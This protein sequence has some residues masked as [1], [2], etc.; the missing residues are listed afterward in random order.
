MTARVHVTEFTDPAC[1]WAWGSEPALRWLARV[2]AGRVAWRRVFGILFDE[3]EDP[4]PDPEAETRWY[5]RF[6][7]G[8]AAHTH[9]PYAARLSRVSE[10]SWP[11][12]LAARAAQ[13]QG[14][15][16]AERVLRRL[17]EAALVRGVP[18]DRPAEVRTAVAGVP[19][20]DE[21]RL[22]ADLAAP[23]VRRAVRADWAETRRPEPEVL[24]LPERG[25]H[26]GRAKELAEGYRYAL[27][28]LVFSGPGGRYVAPGWRSPAEYLACAERAAGEPLP[29]PAPLPAAQAL[30]HYRTLTGP[31]L[32]LLTAE[33]EPPPGA[34]EFATP[35][36]SLWLHP[37]EAAVHPATAG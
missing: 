15:A 21:E 7:A 20:L 28:T 27:P 23:R 34:V 2:L 16:V 24:H 13:E 31:E 33:G 18:A 35:T 26:G 36:G 11:A 8:V 10:S 1:P 17:R 3:D 30:A 14:P 22:L 19:G 9:A 6:V 29:R 5:E 25:P 4:P 37:E 32:R 12:C